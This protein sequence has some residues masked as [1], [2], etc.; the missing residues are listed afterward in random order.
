MGLVYSLLNSLSNTRCTVLFILE[1]S[2]IFI[3]L[4]I[5]HFMRYKII[6]AEK[7]VSNP[8]INIEA[9]IPKVSAIIPARIARSRN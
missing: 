7:I 6:P 9:F 4:L 8:I 5:P 1:P 2:K 3:E